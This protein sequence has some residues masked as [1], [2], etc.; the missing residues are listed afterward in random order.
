MCLIKACQQVGAT[1]D[2]DDDLM[3]WKIEQYTWGWMIWGRKLK[4]EKSKVFKIA[5]KKKKKKLSTMLFI[6]IYNIY[7]IF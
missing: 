4:C 1:K 3:I 2:D 6:T 5:K 7:F